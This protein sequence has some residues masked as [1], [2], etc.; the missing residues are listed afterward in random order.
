MIFSWQ[1]LEKW[2]EGKGLLS[3]PFVNGGKRIESGQSVQCFHSQFYAISIEQAP[4]LFRTI[5]RARESG[6]CPVC[7]LLKK[8]KYIVYEKETVKVL[9]HP[10][11]ERNFTFLIAPGDEVAKLQGVDAKHLA[12][13]FTKAIT[14]YKAM[15]G[16]IPAYNI[17]VRSGDLVGHVHAEIIPKTNTNVPAGFEDAARQMVITQDPKDFADTI[18]AVPGLVS[19]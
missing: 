8:D 1:I 2:A 18:K 6:G 4:S 9:V 17:A 3:I 16:Q 15:F 12:D 11:P 19:E 7:E 14:I 10:F 13:A 5:E